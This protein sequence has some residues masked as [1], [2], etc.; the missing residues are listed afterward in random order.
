MSWIRR[1]AS[2]SDIKNCS[3]SSLMFSSDLLTFC[4]LFV[5]SSDEGIV[6]V[7]L[8]CRSPAMRF[9]N[10]CSFA[11]FVCI[12]SAVDV[13]DSSQAGHCGVLHFSNASTTEVSQ[14]PKALVCHDVSW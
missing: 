1:T 10:A 6:V 4:L 2:W 11:F 3:A 8:S 7:A 5:T 12:G 14:L 13:H 9:R